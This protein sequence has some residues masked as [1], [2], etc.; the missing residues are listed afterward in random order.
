M[1]ESV[2]QSGAASASTTKPAAKKAA[3]A[4]VPAA[5][6]AE[7]VLTRDELKAQSEQLRKELAATLDQVTTQISPK[8]QAKRV[9]NNAK[10]KVQST[11][12]GFAAAAK[13][14]GTDS[15]AFVSGQGLPEDDTRTRNL[16]VAAGV[17]VVA[18]ALVAAGIVKAAK[19]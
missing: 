12:A 18:L 4:K 3:G 8:Y 17:A 13:T 16:Y 6:P 5:T 7:P 10:V 14:A 15:A 2:K 11:A 19:K 9:T 1:S